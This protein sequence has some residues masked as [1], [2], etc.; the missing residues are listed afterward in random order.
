MP[1]NSRA[2]SAHPY[3]IE[4]RGKII[5]CRTLEE[6]KAA[7]SELEGSRL[8]REGTPWTTEEFR[9]FTGRI[10]IPQRRLLAKLLE[11]GPDRWLEDAGLRGFLALPDNN[12]LAGSLS[13]IS[14]VAQMFGIEPRRVYTQNT[15]Y[16]HAKAHRT[17]QITAEFAQAAARHKWPS[18]D[19]LRDRF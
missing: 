18:K 16:R 1:P 13:G 5:R 4:Y 14:K 6:M 15:V 11:N 7:L 10:R 8:I 9:K 12:S 3:E 19:D 17:Y 2:A